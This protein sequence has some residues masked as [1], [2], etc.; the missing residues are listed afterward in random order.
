MASLVTSATCSTVVIMVL[1]PRGRTCA[2]GA[3]Q[4]ALGHR[5]G[6]E[7]PKPVL[8]PIAVRGRIVDV[9]CDIARRT[10]TVRRR[11]LECV[12]TGEAPTGTAL[13]GR[14]RHRHRDLSRRRAH[15][16]EATQDGQ[17]VRLA[18]HESHAQLG[19]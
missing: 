5:H 8:L 16:L 15:G 12:A 18:G 17:Q 10:P 1:S 6:L 3:V 2:W 14:S 19:R 9:R 4:D 11:H 13:G 7:L